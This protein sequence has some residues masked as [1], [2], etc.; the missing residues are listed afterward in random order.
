MPGPSGGA[1]PALAPIAGRGELRPPANLLASAAPQDPAFLPQPDRPIPD[2]PKELATQLELVTGELEASIDRWVEGGDPTVPKV[3]TDVRLQALY[4]QR[5][6]RAMV[7]DERLADRTIA[8]LPV[9]LASR[10]RPT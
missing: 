6:Y 8:R 9:G 7:G 5:I 2:D 10:A 1:G 4:Q 3:P